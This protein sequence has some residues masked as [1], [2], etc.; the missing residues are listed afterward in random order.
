[1]YLHCEAACGRC[2]Y[3][4]RNEDK[5]NRMLLHPPRLVERIITEF[6]DENIT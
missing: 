4:I 3:V 1:M 5:I 6:L 2:G